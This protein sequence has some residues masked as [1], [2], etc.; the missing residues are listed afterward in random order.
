V[1]VPVRWDLPA[2][3][4]ERVLAVIE[5]VLALDESDVGWVTSSAAAS[6]EADVEPLDATSPQTHGIC[7]SGSTGTPKVIVIERPARWEPTQS[8]PFPA[9]WI[10]IERPQTVLVPAPMYH[11]N[12][13][14][15][16]LS[17]LGGDHLVVLERFDPGLV[18]DVIEQHRITCFTATPTMLQRIARR[19]DIDERDLRSLVWVL[20]GAAVIPDSLVH[21]WIE[22]VGADHLFMAYGMTEGLGLTALSG[23]EWLDHRGSVGRGHRGTEVRILDADG[24]DLPAGELGEIYLRWPAGAL[25]RY[26][27]DAARLR[28]A[29]AGFGSAGDLGWLDADGYL[30]IADRRD[31]LIVTGGANVF[32]AEVE[33]ALIDHPAIADVVVIGL[34]DPEWG[35]RVHAIVEPADPA[36]PPS[37]DDVIAFAKSRLASYKAPKTVELVDRLPR[38]EATKISRA[39][40]A[41]ER[42]AASGTESDP[43]PPAG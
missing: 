4:R 19:A 18:L 15:T 11:T 9:N 29:S 31:D 40:L 37:A 30:H 41:A 3:E 36:Q 24:R 23:R 16:L 8:E 27:G 14:A 35:H 39:A 2:W 32:P 7:S 17:L 20:Q 1:P 28:T 33:S 13:F 21:R 38:S 42:D 12:G 34:T 25:Y 6:D 5:P 43:R 22:L 10:P 26:L